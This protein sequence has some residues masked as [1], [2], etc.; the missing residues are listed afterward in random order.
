MALKYLVLLG[1]LLWVLLRAPFVFVAS[2]TAPWWK[3]P[4]DVSKVRLAG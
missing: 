3:T 2:W 1:Q 4:K